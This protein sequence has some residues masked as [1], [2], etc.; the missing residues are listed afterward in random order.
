MT[1]ILKAKYEDRPII[2]GEMEIQCAVLEDNTRVISTRGTERALG[3]GS[4][5]KKHGDGSL[6]VYLAP[7]NLKPFIDSELEAATTSPIRY[8]GKGGIAHG[9]PATLLP[10]ICDVWLRARE[11][12]VLT[13]QQQ[14]TA[15]RAE[16]L[17]RGFAQV[18]II[19]LVD[20]ATGYQD[21]RV[22]DALNIILQKFLRDEAKKYKVTFPIDFYRTIFKLNGWAWSPQSAQ[23]KPM[24]VAKWTNDLVYERLAPGLLN[25]LKIKNPS[26]EG[27][28]HYKHFQF[29][30][31]QVGEPRLIEHFG[32]LI[33][34]GRVAPNWRKFKE[35]V[36]R[37]Y[38][39]NGTNL[40]LELDFGEEK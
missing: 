7:K 30:S 6:P 18:G 38:P 34:L 37:A 1:K 31:D 29:L 19:A 32:G 17:V 16:M 9:I 10:K 27:K 12:G 5:G 2:I 26:I 22:K 3:R 21:H 13:P 28:R 15:K 14:D 40:M 24:V 35:M 11:A 33:A 23:K 39:K 25:E 36:E 4:K 8:K 20:E